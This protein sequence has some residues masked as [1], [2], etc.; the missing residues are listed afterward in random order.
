MATPDDRIVIPAHS[1]ASICWSGDDLVDWIHGCHH[2]RLDGFVS[3]PHNIFYGYRF[4]ATVQS[5]SGRFAVIYEQLATKAL[6]LENGK[7]IRELNRS[8]YQA[9][10]YDYPVCLFALPDGREVIAHCPEDYNRIDI[11]E[12]ET[13]RR[14]TSRTPKE[15]A[16]FFH[17]RLRVTDDGCYLASAGWVWHPVDCLALYDIMEC[18]DNPSLLDSVDNTP[19][20]TD[21][22]A[23]AE[24]ID[25]GRMLIWISGEPVYATADGKVSPANPGEIAVYDLTLKSYTCRAP[26][27]EP[28]GILMPLND[29]FAVGFYQYPK[30]IHIPTGRVR[31]RW[32][33]IDSGNIESSISWHLKRV[34]IALDGKNRR[35]A[36]ADDKKITVVNIPPELTS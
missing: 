20:Y 9:D 25:S 32:P 15:P 6:V 19:P 27:E 26:L 1:V 11:E 30:L 36:V 28:A 2:Y 16:D 34:P 4:D 29:E 24:F 33:D 23:G 31:H 10:V 35:F 12:L 8:F 13:G 18:L 3:R 5:P 22:I 7:L 21:E 14:L 17:S